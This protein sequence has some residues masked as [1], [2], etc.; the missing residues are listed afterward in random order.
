MTHVVV[1]WPI[2]IVDDIIYGRPDDVLEYMKIN[3]CSGMVAQF[4]MF[5]EEV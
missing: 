3:D 1:N 4:T 5:D 2:V